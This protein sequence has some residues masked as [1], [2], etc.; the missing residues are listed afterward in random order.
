M[1]N[2]TSMTAESRGKWR[3][4][5]RAKLLIEGVAIILAGLWALK[6]YMETEWPAQEKRPSIQGD[7]AFVPRFPGIRQSLR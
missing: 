1:L 3:W 2:S 4:V 7:R 6:L 5:E